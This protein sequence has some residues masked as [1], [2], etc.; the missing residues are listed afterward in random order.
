LDP[1]FWLN[2][3]VIT[4]GY[5]GAFIVCLIGNV[6]IIFP[7]PFA[8]VVYSF[9]ATLNPTLLGIVCGIGS[10]IGEMSSY[11]IGRGSRKIFERRYGARLDAVE[12]LIDKNGSFIVFLV[13]LL[14]IPDDLLLIPL[15]MIKYSATKT[16]FAML[17]GKTTLC[18]VLAYAGAYSFDSIK[19]LFTTGGVTE[20][21]T[22]ILLAGI[23]IALIKIDWT[24]M[25]NDHLE[26][27]D[28]TK[29]DQ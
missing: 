9:G 16:L 28:N 24:K 4:Y 8:L 25:L 5:I 2:N 20:V 18:I 7:I 13:A 17:I 11:L 19:D 27:T 12:K 1:W 22:L 21:T 29:T 3:L 6:S 14:P 23:I 15:G 26:K 10:T